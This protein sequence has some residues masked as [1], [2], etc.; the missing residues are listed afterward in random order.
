MTKHTRTFSRFKEPGDFSTVFAEV[1]QSGQPII[2]GK[3]SLQ[4][5]VVADAPQVTITVE[6]TNREKT[7]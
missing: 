2:I 7:P 4:N 3:L 6:T 5:W 1:Q